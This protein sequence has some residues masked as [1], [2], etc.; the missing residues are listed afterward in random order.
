MHLDITTKDTTP[1][2]LV[3][4]ADVVPGPQKADYRIV[5]D[6]E[7]G[8]A[9]LFVRRAL[10]PIRLDTATRP[11]RADES[12]PW[13]LY[14][15]IVNRDYPHYPKKYGGPLPA[16]FQD[17][18]NLVKGDWDPKSKDYDSLS[19]WQVDD[20]H[21]TIRLRIPWSMLGLADPSSKTAL[22]EGKAARMQ[23]IKAIT[24]A[25]DADGATDQLRFEW[26]AWNYTGSK[27]RLLAG[28]D[29]VQKAMRDLAP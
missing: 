5:V 8:K 20:A 11:Y 26:P 15:L 7:A 28:I 16:E 17:V 4:E 27:E 19:T 3:V 12:A 6:R 9:Q 1:K 18:G 10:D 22:G 25:F 29:Q 2:K 14:S 23:K 24:F 13:H 21:D